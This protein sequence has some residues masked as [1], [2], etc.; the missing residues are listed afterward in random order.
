MP[1]VHRYPRN[2]PLTG[3]EVELALIDALDRA[4][5]AV[6]EV[7]R[8]AVDLAHAET[9][10]RITRAR[11]TL[12]S[13]GKTG[14]DREANGILNAEAELRDRNIADALHEGAVEASR[15]R[16]LE[17]EVLRTLAAN[18]RSAESGRG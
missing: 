3:P 4:E 10:Y 7:E 11:Q 12:R 5:D 16:R 1:A 6:D 13:P 14:V 15:L 8:R 2:R 17:V 9:T 18:V